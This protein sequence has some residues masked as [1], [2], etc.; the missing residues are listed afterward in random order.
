MERYEPQAIEKKWQQ[1]WKNEELFKVTEDPCRSKFYYL[2]MFPYP[3]GELHMGHM[4]NY[5]IGDVLSRYM[6]MKGFNVL[7]PMGYDAFGLP[8]E[9]AAI[10]YGY[11]PRDW[12]EQ[13]ICRMRSQF[14]ML[15]ISYDWSRE[16]RTC[17][18]DYYRWNQWLFL[19]MYE[20]G[21]AYRQPAPVNW[22][23]NCE[24][25]LADEEVVDGRCWRC[26]TLVI[27][28]WLEQWFLRTTAYAERLLQDL[29][30]LVHWPERVRIM[31]RNW[32]GKSHG[33]EFTFAVDGMDE[34][35]PV[36]TTR[37]DTVYGVTFVALA[38]ENP[39]VPKLIAR[40]PRRRELEEG[41][42]RL[43]Q[44][45]PEERTSEEAQ[46]RGVFLDVFAIHPLTGER[47]P[48]WSADY[49][50]ME[51]GTGAI[52]AVP[53]HDQ[54]DLEF[55]RQ[56]NL[57]V[58]VVIIPPGGSL[59]PES[60]T[61]AYVEPGIMV[62]AGPFTGMDSPSA[63]E[64]IADL[65][66]QKAI[67]RRKVQYRLR[68]WLISRQR[69]W[70]TPIPV[71][72][73]DR[74]GIVPV[75]DDQLPV[76]L[77]AHIR[78]TGKGGAPLSQVPEFV[79]TTCYSCGGTAKRETDTMSTFVDS[80]WYFLRFCDPQNAEDIFDPEKVN[81]WMPVDQYV[82]GIE[83]AVGHLMYS[84]FITKFLY[85]LGLI[86]FQ[87]PFVRL[88]TQGMIYHESYWCPRC[89]V[90]RRPR[91]VVRKTEDGKTVVTCPVCQSP[92]A[93]TLDKMSKSKLNVVTPEEICAGYGADTGRLF[94]LFI[95]PPEQDAEWTSSG[96]EGPFRFLTRLWRLVL[97]N[98]DRFVSDW[99]ERLPSLKILLSGP[100][101]DL[102]R[103]LHQTVKAVT[104]DIND[105]HFNTAVASLME[106]LN[107][108]QDFIEESD[109]KEE[110][111][112]VVYSEAVD[113]LIRL[114]HP[115]APHIA[116]ELFSWHGGQGSL[117][118]QPWPEADMDALEAEMQ[119][120]VVQV[121]GKVRARITVPV[122][123]DEEK[124]KERAL[125]EPNVRAHL[126]G[127]TVVRTI[128]VPNKLINFVVN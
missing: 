72:Y 1:R 83:H 8:A 115:F 82:G 57:P 112:R 93:I 70:G 14:D 17:A 113:T 50:L 118:C 76:L 107:S 36:F 37:I 25:T 40:S 23:P 80:S 69:Y 15:G 59:D 9:N 128:I 90:Y 125:Q 12:V 58:R 119:T 116:D 111:S 108:F 71:I 89:R 123:Y 52:M 101:R 29:D 98:K 31:Q 41:V 32:I 63:A 46:K 10:Q 104:E 105:F 60:M 54:R 21:L 3:S 124:L 42:T 109:R 61:Q 91:D 77:P 30:Q 74:C 81:Y 48:I 13:C 121:N 100:E 4:R 28:K 88:F 120:I 62:N 85:D 103:R 95:G 110:R 96:V 34:T 6:R 47:V 27:K 126:G 53:A 24:T 26:G 44:E 79:N 78:I 64:A 2:D 86:G 19:K 7:H 55:A 66:E 127:K 73:C 94:I 68:D 97:S 114:L 75:P 20:R 33:V 84:R 49:V 65:M 122:G 5:I 18:P 35:I 51:Y 117:I 16:I 92:V 56:Y 43:L 11:H 102:R 39:L 38:P 45:S 67:G 22:C 87:E 99:R 106:F